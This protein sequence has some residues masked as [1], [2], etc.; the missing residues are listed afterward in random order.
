MGSLKM[1]QNTEITLYRVIQELVNNIIKHAGAREA[2]VQLEHENNLITVTVEDNGRGFNTGSLDAAKGIG[3][4]NIRNRIEYLKGKINLVSEKDR[5]TSITI[6]INVSY[7]Q[8][9]LSLM[10]ILW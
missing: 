10:T 3:W 4:S 2:I 8:Q 1:E 5:G 7:L 6:E 9:F